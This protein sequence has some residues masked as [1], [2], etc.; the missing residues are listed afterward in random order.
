MCNSF[1]HTDNSCLKQQSEPKKPKNQ[2]KIWVQK[3]IVKALQFKMKI[4][5]QRK[6]KMSRQMLIQ[7]NRGTLESPKQ[8]RFHI[9]SDLNGES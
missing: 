2:H 4:G 6:A 1:S 3:K 9:L 8:N 7:A 5:A